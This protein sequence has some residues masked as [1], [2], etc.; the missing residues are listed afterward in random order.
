MSKRSLTAASA[1][2][3]LA[4]LASGCTFPASAPA[5]PTVEPSA[6]MVLTLFF[7]NTEMNP[8]ILDCSKVF[9]VERVV[10]AAPEPAE[11]ALLYLF[12]GPTEEERAEG[13]VSTFSPATR[14]VLKGIR[15]ERD[16]AYVNLVDLRP[17]LSSVSSSCGS[18]AF[19][20]EVETTLKGATPVSRVIYAI[21]G[22]PATFYEWVQL[23]C[24][25]DNDFCDRSP[26]AD[27]QS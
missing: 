12:A 5:G 13:Y 7:G 9:P 4:L 22:D 16:T 8:G 10:P 25:A 19:F 24:S 18:S 27:D 2:L 1:M 15:I 20:A 3:I 23:G 26:F 6:T 21:D 14:S 11:T 17:I